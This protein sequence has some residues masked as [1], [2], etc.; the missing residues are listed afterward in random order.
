MGV[1]GLIPKTPSIPAPRCTPG[2]HGTAAAK[3][4]WSR[5]LGNSAA[6]SVRLLPA[7]NF[8]EFLKP[9]LGSR[10]PASAPHACFLIKGTGRLI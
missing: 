2:E 8:N 4:L 9:G 7:L 10:S 3:P 6:R 1:P 5:E